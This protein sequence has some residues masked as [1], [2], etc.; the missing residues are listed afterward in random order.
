MRKWLA[1]APLVLLLAGPADA[2]SFVYLFD[3][4][5]DVINFTVSTDNGPPAKVKDCPN[6]TCLFTVDTTLF[7]GQGVISAYNIWEDAARTVLSDTFKLAIVD[8]IGP[9]QHT[10]LLIEFKSD[11]PF[12]PP[13]S[14]LPN[15]SNLFETG[16]L[17]VLEKDISIVGLPSNSYTFQFISDVEAV[18]GPV[19]GAGVPGLMLAIGAVLGW[20]Q[21]RR[22]TG[23]HDLDN[24]WFALRS[25]IREDSAR[26][27]DPVLG[28]SAAADAIG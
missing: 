16:R 15:A 2:A 24:R 3:D 26:P 23:R 20:R 8:P 13:L 5:T 28:R 21:R 11:S 12:G 9:G 7:G 25:P 14:S 27:R 18:P 22:K 6:E 17:Q 10:R 19:A 4:T 1:V